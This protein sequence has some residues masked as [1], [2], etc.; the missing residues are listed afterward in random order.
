MLFRAWS[1]FLAVMRSG[2]GKELQSDVPLSQCPAAESCG[3]LAQTS[4]FL[5]GM[6]LGAIGDQLKDLRLS[7]L[8]DTLPP[9][10]DE[11]VA[12]S[13]AWPLLLAL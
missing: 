11:A 10:V 9:G 6:G 4:D 5:A 1:C 7:E 2:I 8:L 3:V 13:K 12:I